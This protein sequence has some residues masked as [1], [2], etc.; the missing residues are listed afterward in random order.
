[1][2][3]S[4]KQYSVSI[5]FVLVMLL[6]IGAVLCINSQ[7]IYAGDHLSASTGC[8]NCH[9]SNIRKAHDHDGVAPLD[10]WICHFGGGDTWYL[11]NQCAEYLTDGGVP[12]VEIE[13]D[14]WILD[15]PDYS[16]FNFECKSCHVGQNPEHQQ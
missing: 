10:C 7:A 12:I 3:N 14:A 5:V 9:E 8:T 13:E 11:N 16:D 2:H 4:Q 6:T 1:M 15:L